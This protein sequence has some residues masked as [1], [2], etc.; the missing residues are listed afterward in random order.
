M[1][2][3]DLQGHVKR[4]MMP[5]T[6]RKKRQLL[7]ETKHR[8]RERSELPLRQTSCIFKRPVTKITSHPGNEVRYKKQEENLEKPQQVCAYRRLQGL[9]ACSSEGEPLSTLDVMNTMSTI[10]RRSAGGSLGCAGP[11]SV[12][13][14]PEPTTAGSSNWA[15]IIPG[16]GLYVPQLLCR[17]PVT[18]AHIRRQTLKVKKA[19]ERLA[20]ALRED[21]LAREAER[22][23]SP[24]GRT[25][26]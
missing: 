23:R 12:H 21:R 17:Q 15:E 16:T 19:R 2:K 6:L 4:N 22:A 20:V 11:A 18:R 13:T 3:N 10:A 26:N 14:S 1:A 8:R 5:Q 24:E 25:E 7:S 9:Q